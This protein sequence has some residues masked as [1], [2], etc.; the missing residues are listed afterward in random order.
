MCISR[1]NAGILTVSILLLI[2]PGCGKPE[3]EA[4]AP[5]AESAEQ[6]SA[7]AA[8]PDAATAAPEAAS[9]TA[10]RFEPAAREPA[11]REAAAREPEPSNPIDAVPVEPKEDPGYDMVTVFYATDRARAGVDSLGLFG[12]S[13]W[14]WIAGVLGAFTLGVLIFALRTPGGSEGSAEASSSRIWR[15]FGVGIGL[16]LTI[17]AGAQALS[18]QSQIESIRFKNLTTLYGGDRGTMEYGTCE[19]SIP[20]CHER[21]QIERP[22]MLKLEFRE[23]PLKHLVLQSTDP[24]GEEVFFEELRADVKEAGDDEAFVF[25]HG[26]NV[27]FEAAAMRTAQLSYDLEFA[28]TPILFSW[29]STGYTHLYTTDENNVAWAIP[30]LKQFLTDLIERS[31]AKRIHLIAHSMG[32][33]ALTNAL[34]GLADEFR[35]EQPKPPKPFQDVVLAAPDVDAEIFRRDLAPKI[36]ELA[37]RVTLYASSNDQ[38]LRLSR[39]VH[40]G[41]PRAGETGDNLVVIDGVDTIDVSDVDKSALGHSYVGDNLFVIAD[42]VQLIT[43]AAPPCRTCG[44]VIPASGRLD[45]L[46]IP[47]G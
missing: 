31:G 46:G 11:T 43:A 22:S 20:E 16:V 1:R 41:Y 35:N 15:F 39:K 14:H 37:R 4:G 42:L 5:T 6:P 44:P 3:N 24:K 12:P 47:R 25:V 8:Q 18:L 23:D 29:P 45:L 19:V 34:A 32:N 13:G 38:A 40:G 9:E 30:H 26:Y 10:R 33:R 17:V 21:G 2:C 7:T 27:T 28:G 36:V